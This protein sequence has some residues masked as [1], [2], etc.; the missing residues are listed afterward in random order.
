MC[1]SERQAPVSIKS[2]PAESH[3][4]QK[5]SKEAVACVMVAEALLPVAAPIVP[6]K[7]EAAGIMS[8]EKI[9]YTIQ[10]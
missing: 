9:E 6:L 8:V 10:D 7:A 1:S 3:E 5:D 2:D 4:P